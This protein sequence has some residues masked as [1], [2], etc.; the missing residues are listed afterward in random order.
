MRTSKCG[1]NNMLEKTVHKTCHSSIRGLN[2]KLHSKVISVTLKPQTFPLFKKA[3]VT[4][5]QVC[6]PP[7]L[8]AKYIS[9]KLLGK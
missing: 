2:Y 4:Y 3:L 5:T 9:A 1:E 7:S 6:M 8:S